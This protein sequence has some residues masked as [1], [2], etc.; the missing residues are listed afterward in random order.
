MTYRK[1]DAHGHLLDPDRPDELLKAMDLV[2]I[3]RAAISRPIG[4]NPDQ[5]REQNDAILRAMKMHPDRLLGQCYVNPLH[6]ADALEEVN[7][8]LGEGM[9]G[10]GE[11]YTHAKISNPIYFPIVE[12]CIEERASIMAH[13]R[14]DLSL[15]RP[16]HPETT[17]AT[18]SASKDFVELAKRYP[19]AIIIHGHIGGGGDWEHMVKTLRDAPTIYV[20]TSGSCTDEGMIDFAVRHL[21]VDR[22]LFATDINF[23]TGVGKILAARL[24]E[25]DRR[26]I[27]WGNFNNIL[28]L[29]GQH[30]D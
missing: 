12:K 22:L 20:D 4:D 3:E 30:A 7:R 1:V 2:G 8:C 11:L 26:A 21:G 19:E 23:E 6:A 16:H 29:R 9:I 15:L 10:L 27:F 25:D 28:R 5:F 18:T 24:G 14:A 13:A 17:P